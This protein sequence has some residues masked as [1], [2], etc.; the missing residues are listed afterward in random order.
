MS[1][2]DQQQ[3]KPVCM[4]PT[5]LQVG[6][7]SCCSRCGK[8]RLYISILKPAQGCTNCG[9]DY[10]FIDSGDG[11]AV[12]VILIIGFLVT[13]LAMVVQ[14]AFAIPIWVHMILWIPL[15]TLSSVWGLQV[16]KSIMIALQYKTKAEQGEL[17]G[18][19]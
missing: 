19:G 4:A 5:P 1:R 17:D 12:F 3:D 13:A 7:G 9:L 14:T 18:S 11:P 6:I 8:G 10:S 15:V 2:A 16:T